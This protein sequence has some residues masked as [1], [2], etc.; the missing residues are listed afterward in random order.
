MKVA[1]EDLNPRN[2][3]RDFL[4]RFNKE[5]IFGITLFVKNKDYHHY[6]DILSQQL[7]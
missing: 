1:D 3:I 2:L 4:L 6:P 5:N 7:T